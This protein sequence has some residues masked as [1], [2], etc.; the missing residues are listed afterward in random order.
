MTLNGLRYIRN[1]MFYCDDCAKKN[2]WNITLFKSIGLCEVCNKMRVCSDL[3]SKKLTRKPAFF[4][5]KNKRR[6][7][8]GQ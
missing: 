5:K 4:N 2:D 1:N 6:P 8:Y 7:D 3:P